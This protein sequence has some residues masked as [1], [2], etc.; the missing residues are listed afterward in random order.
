MFFGV[1]DSLMEPRELV[2]SCLFWKD[3]TTGVLADCVF[4]DGG[5]GPL[6]PV[7]WLPNMVVKKDDSEELFFWC[8]LKNGFEWWL[9]EFVLYNWLD[10][11]SIVD[12][13]RGF[14]TESLSL[15]YNGAVPGSSTANG[16]ADATGCSFSPRVR[17]SPDRSA[18]AVWSSDESYEEPEISEIVGLGGSNLGI[19][20]FPRVLRNN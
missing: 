8:L 11:S 14:G 4:E 12:N 10:E 6:V 3:S 7:G 13:G 15:V 18:S 1:V 9:S 17:C 20:A 16:G 5:G 2:R 19:D